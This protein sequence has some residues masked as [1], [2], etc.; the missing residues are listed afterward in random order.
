MKKVLCFGTFDI[1]HKGHKEFLIDAK[2]KGDYLIVIVIHDDLVY[3][4][5]KRSPKN[6][7]KTRALNL[8]KLKLA[9]KIIGV[10]NNRDNNIKLIEKINP[11]IVVLGYDQK[12]GFL[13]LLKN[14]LKKT[15]F[16][17]SKEFAGGIHTS[18]LK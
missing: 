5:K 4:N 12:S 18:N 9:D 11:D 8:K 14:E 17:R 2:K 16:I 7:Q 1:L 3:V 10:S 6:N 13:P 15:K